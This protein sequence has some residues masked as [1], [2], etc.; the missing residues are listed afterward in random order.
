MLVFVHPKT[1]WSSDKSRV[2]SYTPG[3]VKL[4]EGSN[5][6]AFPFVYVNPGVE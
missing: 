6:V 5:A 3:D 4:N 1:C 2:I